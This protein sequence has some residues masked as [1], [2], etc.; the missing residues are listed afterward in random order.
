MEKRENIIELYVIYNALL[1][2]NEKKC[3]EYYYYEDYSL[4]EIAEVIGVSKSYV[5]KVINKI[6]DKLNK[7]ENVLLNKKRKD[8]LNL[9]INEVNDDT[10][11]KKIEEIIEM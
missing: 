1:T 4:T 10:I 5:S 8:M 3:F 6:N 9:L 7:F 11:V 2:E